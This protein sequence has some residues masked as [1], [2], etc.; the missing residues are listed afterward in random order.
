MEGVVESG[1]RDLRLEGV[2]LSPERVAVDRDVDQ[3]QRL[4]PVVLRVG[5]A[6]DEPG[7]GGEDGLAGRDVVSDLGGDP[8]AVDQPRD[9]RRLPARH[10]EDVAVGHDPRVPD[11]DDLRGLVVGGRG[12]ADG[13]GVFGH[14]ALNG[15]DACFHTDR[16]GGRVEKGRATRPDRRA[17]K[18]ERRGSLRDRQREDLDE[19]AE[20][21]A[22]RDHRLGVDRD[23]VPV[24][25]VEVADQSRAGHQ[26]AGV[27]TTHVR[28]CASPRSKRFV[29]RR[30]AAVFSRL[31]RRRRFPVVSAESSSPRNRRLRGIAVSAGSSPPVGRRV[32]GVIASVVPPSSRGF[33]SRAHEW[34][35]LM[36]GPA[37]VEADYD[38]STAGF[39]RRVV[40]PV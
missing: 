36:R 14:V 18:R 32:R 7:A 23:G 5:R 37:V 21:N 24:L 39:P 40:R 38:R 20:E 28:L 9:G 19:H 6:D 35:T 25:V 22:E 29:R 26:P 8:L 13:G 27:G 1:D 4:D 12:V 34:E 11:L 17:E 33:V 2:L 10:E 3:P 16:W 31:F 30:D 15:D